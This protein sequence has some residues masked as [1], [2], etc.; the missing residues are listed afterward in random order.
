M[1]TDHQFSSLELQLI[2]TELSTINYDDSGLGDAGRLPLGF[3]LV[4]D[5]HP[6]QHLAEHDVLPVQLLRQPL[7][8]QE[9]DSRISQ[10]KNHLKKVGEKPWGNCWTV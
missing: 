3:D 2:I 9:A 4:D 1:C 7:Q 10:H 5:V 6:V 8:E